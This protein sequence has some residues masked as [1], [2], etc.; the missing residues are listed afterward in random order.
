[1]IQKDI[2]TALLTLHRRVAKDLK[3]EHVFNKVAETVRSL[4]RSDGCAILLMD[5][6]TISVVASI[7]FSKKTPEFSASMKPIRDI[8]RTGKGFINNDVE[9][10]KLKSCL[11]AGCH[12]KSILCFPIKQNGQV[13]GIIHLDSKKKNA[14]TEDDLNFV[15]IVSS[16]LTSIMERS[17]LYSKLE[18]MSIKDPLTGCFNRKNISLDIKK[19][20]ERC[21]R[22]K[23]TF[24]LLVID[25]DNFKKY[26][27]TFG[28]HRGDNLLK[29][30]AEKIRRNLR[31]ADVVYRYGGDEFVVLLPETGKTGA[32]VCA[33]R[34]EDMIEK[35]NMKVDKHTRITLSTGMAGYPENGDTPTKIIKFADRQMYRNKFLKKAGR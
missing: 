32:M 5:N 4:I 17:F 1:M 26:N 24:S 8:I 21:K 29:T 14:F 6:N 30:I 7:G 35:L 28:H 23:K 31:K 19:E 10:S 18:E 2:T 9:K 33:K 15:K 3:K 12:M 20:I 13:A 11:P 22:Y 25:L 27:D 34:L 16:E